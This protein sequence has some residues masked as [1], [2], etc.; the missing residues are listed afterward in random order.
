MKRERDIPG[1]SG[2]GS[3]L[4]PEAVIATAAVTVGRHSRDWVLSLPTY[5]D[6]IRRLTGAAPAAAA[7]ARGEVNGLPLGAG[8][9]GGMSQ[10]PQAPAAWGGCRRGRNQNVE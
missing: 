6:S 5:R 8:K 2:E 1:G 4:R 10:S 9:R 3:F 7:G